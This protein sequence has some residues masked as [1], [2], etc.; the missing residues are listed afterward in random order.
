MYNSTPNKRLKTIF[1]LSTQTCS[2]ILVGNKNL[3]S[4]I[5]RRWAT[6]NIND[7]SGAFHSIGKW[8]IKFFDFRVLTLYRDHLSTDN[9][10]FNVIIPKEIITTVENLKLVQCRRIVLLGLT[11]CLKMPLIFWLVSPREI[12][13]TL[14]RFV[15]K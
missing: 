9:P 8:L 14:T 1:D 13:A 4:L 12:I 7:V 2:R 10:L 6:N 3:Y 11:V 5:T 15:Q